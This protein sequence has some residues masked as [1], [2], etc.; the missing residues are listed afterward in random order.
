MSGVRATQCDELRPLGQLRLQRDVVEI[1]PARPRRFGAVRIDGDDLEIDALAETQAARCA[2][3]SRHACRPGWGVDAGHFGDE[4]DAVGERRRGERPDGRARRAAPSRRTSVIGLRRQRSPSRRGRRLDRGRRA[5][6]C[7]GP[8]AGGN[9]SAEPRASSFA[10]VAARPAC[11][12]RHVVD[13]AGRE[14]GARTAADDMQDRA[15][16]PRRATRREN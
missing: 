15:A 1:E 8:A 10:I 5:A 3:P 11:G 6:T 16:R 12:E 13:D 7:R 14:L 4:L 2:S 9:R